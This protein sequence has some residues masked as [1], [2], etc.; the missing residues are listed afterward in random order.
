M[1]AR[2]EGWGNL[3]NARDAHYFT[4]DGRSLCNRWL[5]LRSPRWESY[6]E[7]GAAPTKGTCKTCWKKLAKQGIKR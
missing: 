7:L 6:Q 3:D 5:A 2:K 4:V 1:S